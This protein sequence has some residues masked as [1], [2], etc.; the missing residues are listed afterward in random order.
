MLGEEASAG[1][2]IDGNLTLIQ[3]RQRLFREHGLYEFLRVLGSVLVVTLRLTLEAKIVFTLFLLHID[4][5][6]LS[7]NKILLMQPQWQTLYHILIK[8]NINNFN[9]LHRRHHHHS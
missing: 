6:K 9:S 5:C 1:C 3:V 4:I 8:F 7:F 2:N